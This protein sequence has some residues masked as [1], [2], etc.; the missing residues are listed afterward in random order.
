MLDFSFIF[1]KT[2]KP[3]VHHPFNAMYA[4]LLFVTIEFV[5]SMFSK[6]RGQAIVSFFTMLFHE[7]PHLVLLK[8]SPTD[9]R[10][11]S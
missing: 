5:I 9:V 2:T 7:H 11:L 4:V 10:G 8:F 6:V 3:P 1:A